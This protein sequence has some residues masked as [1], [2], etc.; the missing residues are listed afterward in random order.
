M[1]A[2]L[3]CPTCRS[4]EVHE[5]GHAEGGLHTLCLECQETRFVPLRPN[6]PE[7][8]LAQVCH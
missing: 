3:Y 8:A 1:I 5:I 2:I 7:V 6:E 4:E